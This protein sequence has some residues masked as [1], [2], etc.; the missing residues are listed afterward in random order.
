[1]ADGPGFDVVTSRQQDDHLDVGVRELK[2]KLSDY[3]PTKDMEQ[4]KANARAAWKSIPVQ[5][6][7]NFCRRFPKMIMEH[8]AAAARR[9]AKQ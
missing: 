3:A 8:R 5:E 7:N 1:M 9:A 2:R 6:M 4:F